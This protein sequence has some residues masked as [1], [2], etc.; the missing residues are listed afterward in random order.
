MSAKGTWTITRRLTAATL[1]LLLAADIGL[2]VFLWRTSRQGPA[3]IRAQRD[4]LSL[5]AKVRNA[6]VARGEKISQSLP[7][8]GLDCEKFYHDTFLDKA[9]GYSA[10][11]ADLSSIADKAGL[12]MSGI[13]YKEEPVKNRGVTEISITTGVEGNYSAIIQFING[14]EQSKNFYLLND[15]RLT[16]AKAGAIKLELALRTYFRS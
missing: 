12:R 13:S 4:R 7:H 8:V 10:L 15:L 14:L 16:S 3:E 5:E 6:E 2:V 1:A 11:E 9:S